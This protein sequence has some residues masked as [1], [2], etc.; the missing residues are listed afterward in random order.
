MR[1]LHLRTGFFAAVMA[2]VAT[3]SSAASAATFYVQ[4]DPSIPTGSGSSVFLTNGSARVT[5]STNYSVG[6]PNWTNQRAGAFG[7]QISPSLV[8]PTWSSFMTYCIELTQTLG[9]PSVTPTTYVT[10]AL[11]AVLTPLKESLIER[12]W[13]QQ[14]GDSVTSGLRTIGTVANTS[15]AERSSAFQ[16]TIWDIVTDGGD[17]A[18]AGLFRVANAGTGNATFADQTRLQTLISEYLA[19][20]SSG[21]G[22]TINLDAL[23]NASRQDLLIPQVSG[24]PDPV[25]VP[26]SLALLSAGLVALAGMR[27]GIG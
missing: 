23:T 20:A 21:F 14:F 25:P 1:K 4:D 17:G 18:S 11:S 19:I 13:A 15:Q 16:M 3:I 9:L 8:G 22:P 27:R 24:A 6:S 10:Q 26:A 12:L 5:L 7:L 2:A